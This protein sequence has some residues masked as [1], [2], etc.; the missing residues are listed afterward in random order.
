MDRT[1]L[2]FSHILED[3]GILPTTVKLKYFHCTCVCKQWQSKHS[4]VKIKVTNKH[5][6][7]EQ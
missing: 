5:N 4:M 3:A 6:D 2:P 1:E 7:L